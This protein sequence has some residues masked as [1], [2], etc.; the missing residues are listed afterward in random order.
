MPEKMIVAI[1]KSE[2]SSLAAQSRIISKIRNIRINKKINGK[3]NNNFSRNKSNSKSKNG[4][5]YNRKYNKV[6]PK[7]FFTLRNMDIR[8]YVEGI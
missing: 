5:S 4:K 3:Y 1:L 2:P 6:K 7:S 8:V